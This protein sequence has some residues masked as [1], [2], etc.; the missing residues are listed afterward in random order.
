VVPDGARWRGYL[1]TITSDALMTGQASSPFWSLEVDHRFV[2]DGRGDC[3]PL[4]DLDPYMRSR[5][6]LGHFDKLALELVSRA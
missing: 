5:R 1:P 6:T 4:A 3:D 2:C